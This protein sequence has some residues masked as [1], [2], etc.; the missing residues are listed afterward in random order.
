MASSHIGVQS[1]CP[2]SGVAGV[3][4]RSLHHGSNPGKA[5]GPGS[6]F[7]EFWAPVP[8]VRLLGWVKFFDLLQSEHTPQSLP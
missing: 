3:H 8:A 1:F 6:L 7:K 5:V 4:T 2:E